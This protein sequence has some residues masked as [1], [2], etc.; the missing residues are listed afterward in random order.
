M[1]FSDKNVEEIEK[2]T[3][4]WNVDGIITIS[5]PYRHLQKIRRVV[6]NTYRFHRHG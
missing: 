5:M 2:M 4:G 3:V 1:I 6:R